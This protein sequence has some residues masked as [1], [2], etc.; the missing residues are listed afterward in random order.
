MFTKQVKSESERL[1]LKPKFLQILRFNENGTLH[2]LFSPY[3][4]E[5]PNQW[6]SDFPLNSHLDQ[7]RWWSP[8][9]PGSQVSSE[10]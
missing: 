1:L 5:Q 2:R 10:S 8:K 9:D 3:L 6:D 7:L 4:G